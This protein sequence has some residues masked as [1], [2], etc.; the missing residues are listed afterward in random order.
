MIVSRFCSDGTVVT[1]G[2][3]SNGQLGNNS[4]TNSSVPVAVTTS[5]VLSGKTVVTAIAAGGSSRSGSLHGWYACLPGASTTMASWAITARQTAMYRWLLR[6]RE[7]FPGKTVVSMS[8]GAWHSLAVCSDGTVA[9]WGYNAFGQLGNNSTINSHVPI[10]ITSSGVL[11]GKTVVSVSGGVYQSVALC[12]DGTVAAWGQG[13]SGQLGNGT[14]TGEL[15][16]GSRNHDFVRSRH[17][18]RAGRHRCLFLVRS[19]SRRFSI[20]VADHHQRT[21]SQRH[22]GKSL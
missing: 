20:R 6:H 18:F 15:R 13:G 14:T 16:T 11:S 12:S 2:R 19:C 22:I 9:A 21:R 4:T 7:C 3:N 5:G 10:A 1:W 8:G 17:T